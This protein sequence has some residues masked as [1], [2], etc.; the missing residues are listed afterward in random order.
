M[1]RTLVLLALALLVGTATGQPDPK[2]KPEDKKPVTRVHNLKPLLG[3]RG[4]ASGLADADAVIKVIFEAIPEL[5]DLK[6]GAD[7]PQIVELD[8]GKLEVRAP[9]AVQEQV[10]DLL[11]ALARLQDVAVDVKVEVLELSTGFGTEQAIKSLFQ[12]AKGKP[13]SPAAVLKAGAEVLLF[14]DV[15]SVQTSSARLVNGAEATV[16]AR[17]TLAT[18]SNAPNGDVKKDEHP[19]F[20]KEGFSLQALPTVSADRRFIRFKLTEQSTV[21]SGTTKRP[22]GELGGKPIV[23]QTLDTED[24]GATGSAVVADGGTLL[25]RLAYAPKGKV[26]VVVLKPTI[27]IQS[28]E[29]ERNRKEKR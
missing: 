24:L 9:A 10:K 4:K 5:R 25:F 14:K 22:L 28:E 29:D 6:P 26:W 2:K 23:F 1:P 19:L 27:F 11:E 7:G 3:E 17:R 20:V 21:I 8:G 15:R 13:E 18:F 12:P 16:T